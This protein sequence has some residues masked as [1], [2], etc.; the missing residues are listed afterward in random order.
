MEIDVFTFK[1][2]ALASSSAL[3]YYITKF[4]SGRPSYFQGAK[5]AFKEGTSFSLLFSI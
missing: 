1:K 5:R 2:K 3:L 4:L